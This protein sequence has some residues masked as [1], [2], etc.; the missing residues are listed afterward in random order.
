MGQLN[1]VR[2]LKDLDV[3]QGS[4]SQEHNLLRTDSGSLQPTAAQWADKF[5]TFML[6]SA[7]APRDLQ[8]L[9]ELHFFEF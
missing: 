5:R 4:C 8:G 1:L 2:L 7:I 6:L 3:A 9:A